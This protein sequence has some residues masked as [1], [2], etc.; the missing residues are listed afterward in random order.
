[1]HDELVLETDK[2][3]TEMWYDFAKNAMLNAATLICPSVPF[4]VEGH[5]G[6]SWASKSKNK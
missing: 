3:Y 6:N 1:M 2:N 5:I 4:T